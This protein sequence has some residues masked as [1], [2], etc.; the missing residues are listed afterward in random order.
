MRA[1]GTR[2]PRRLAYAGENRNVR[3]LKRADPTS[4]FGEYATLVGMT[5]TVMVLTFYP[6]AASSS[7]S[8]SSAGGERI[9]AGGVNGIFI[10]EL[11]AGR[12]QPIMTIPSG[13]APGHDAQVECLCWIAGATTLVSGS[14]DATFKMWDAV[15][16]R[17]TLLET[18]DDH[19]ASVLC[20]AYSERASLLATTGRDSSIKVWDASTLHIKMRTK[21]ADDSSVRIGLKLN[22]EGH[23][24][25]VTA[26]GFAESAQVLFSGARDNTVKIWELVGGSQV[27]SLAAHKADVRFLQTISADKVLVTGS[28]DGTVKFWELAPI[29]T[30]RLTNES[31]ID[32]ILNAQPTAL[33]EEA[34]AETDV[35][36][37]TLE[38][39]SSGVYAVQLSPAQPLCMLTAARLNE[40]RVWSLEDTSAPREIQEVAGHSGPVTAVRLCNDDAWCAARA[41]RH[42]CARA[43]VRACALG[44]AHMRARARRHR[45]AR[46]GAPALERA[47]LATISTDFHL[48]LFS[49]ADGGLIGKVNCGAGMFALTTTPDS[50]LVVAGGNDFVIK[51]RARHWRRC[52]AGR[53]RTARRSGTL[54]RAAAS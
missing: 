31:D 28:L 19:K 32:K 26:I 39:H 54:V 51:A 30:K 24:G 52:P 35:L 8:S 6:P 16:G 23:R 13:R 34:L 9:C 1:L 37:N 3:V 15:D 38:A 50:D 12:M 40:V 44:D 48:Y 2:L 10:W 36:L 20:L 17:F 42:C 47:R 7:A 53:A 46:T 49:T 18:N 21:R 45:A 29:E 41:R 33:V 22:L 5:D 25:D 14:K 11:S 4:E 43:R 27:R